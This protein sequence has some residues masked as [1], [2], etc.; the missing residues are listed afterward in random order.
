MRFPRSVSQCLFV[1]ALLGGVRVCA[2]TH[3]TQS[4]IIDPI[5]ETQLT[6]LTGNTPPAAIATN[7]RG[8]V[9]PDLALTDLV[10][11]L[12][13]SS[14]Q[15]AAFDTFV[16]SQYDASSPNFHHWLTPEE[17]GER[18]GPSASDIATISNWLTG[19]GLAISAVSKD[20]L[21]IHFGGTAARV[22][23]AF[24][25]EIHNL[26]VRGEQH[27]GNVS[28][29]QIPTA[30]G[31]VVLGVK[32]LHDFLPR[33]QHRMGSEVILD[34]QTG[35]WQR[36][37][38][39][40]GAARLPGAVP[41]T[42]AS[43]DYGITVGSG[44]N[45][46]TEEDVSPYD[47][48][49][50][51]NVLPL[52]N[53][54]APIDGTNQTIAIAGTSDIILSDVATFRQAFGLPAGIAP[55]MVV[56]NGVDPG[57]CTADFGPC[58][59]D[60][61]VENTLDV[62]L[63]GAV[64]KGASVILV[65]SGQT[66]PTTDKVFSS[67]DYVVENLTSKILSL[68]YGQC[69]LGLGTSGNAAY[70]NLWESAA[71]EG[72]AVFV[73]TGD[74]GSAACDQGLAQSVP[75]TAVY[76][77]SVNGLA[78]SAYDTAVGGTDLNWGSTPA[79]YWNA[80]NNATTGA[81][82]AGY[83]PEVPWN[84]TCT[85]PLA[86]NYLQQWA[87]VLQSHGY[88]ATSPTDPETACNFVVEWWQTIYENTSPTVNI[89]E[90]VNTA[91]AGGGMSNCTANDGETVASCTGGYPK[92]TWQT[93][94]SG[95]PADGKRDLP[96]VSFFSSNG[97]LGSAT[98]IC[99]T[100][101]GAFQCNYS[102]TGQLAVE[103][104]GGTSVATP[105]M[106]GV[107]ALINQQA[108]TTQGNPNAELYQLAS[109]QTYASCKSIG[110]KT[111]NGCFFN[112]INDGTIAMP[113]ES[114][115]VDCTVLHSGDALGILGGY[116]GATGFDLATGLGSLNVDNVV[117]NWV[118]SLGTAAVTVT[119]TPSLGSIPIDQSLSVPVTVSG[120]GGTPTGTVELVGG[121]YTSSVGTLSN[122]AYTF[123]IPA[124]GLS[125]GNDTLTISYSGDATFGAAT[126]TAA[127]TVTKLSPSI[128]VMANPST[129][130]AN[131]GVNVG[132]TVTGSGP[133]PTGTI[134][135]A[136]GGYT[137]GTCTLASGLCTVNIPVNTLAN[138][139]DTL[140]ASYS[141][142][143]DYVAG[144]GSES[145]TV[146]ALTPTVSV[147]ATPS[148]PNTV[149]PMQVTVTVTGT[150]ATPSGTVN[151]GGLIGTLAGGT[152]TFTMAPGSIPG[153]TE[154]LIIEYSGDLTY[155]P[156]SGNVTVTVTKV[157]PTITMTPSATSLNTNDAFTITG[158]VTSA[159]ETPTGQVTVTGG[160]YALI[161]YVSFQGSY[162]IPVQPGALSAGTDTLTATYSGDS[163]FNSATTSTTLS[164]MQ[165]VQIAP[166]ITI[167]FGTN[168]V[169]T[170]ES[171]TATVTVSGTDGTPTGTV[172]ASWNGITPP[173]TQL[174]GGTANFVVPGG[175][176]PVGTYTM[177]VTYGGDPTYL[178][179]STASSFSVTQST[180]GIAATSSGSV[181]PGSLA[182]STITVSSN[183]GFSGI[184][185]LS[186]TLTSS[187]AGASVA[188]QPTCFFTSNMVELNSATT[189]ETTTA[190]VQ[191]TPPATA[192]IA[193]PNLP[194]RR[195]LAAASG[196]VFAF[197]LFLGI[198]SRRSWRRSMLGLIVLLAAICGI[199]SC[200]GNGGGG[201]GG[202]G[203]NTG[204][205]P[206][207]YTFTVTGSTSQN[208]S[209]TPTAT[210][211][212][213]VE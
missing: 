187:P 138:G 95:I 56:G 123:A 137:S 31:P 200:G 117:T 151:L 101:Y 93:N 173:A 165:F 15:Q 20:R 65:V 159:A 211:T 153:G 133:T 87:T 84:D 41:D 119:A 80:T 146:T 75:Y 38:T 3:P 185:N 111:T 92:P 69:E 196:V 79:P 107:M 86:L 105:E 18:F 190:Q 71:T 186:C 82:A 76:G 25:T 206:G 30:L 52:W 169:G 90:F 122:G 213:T 112:D 55:Q 164:V 50:I 42:L 61:L 88:P 73:A 177:S 68:S 197:L 181:E 132:V 184:V 96:D 139:V 48:A 160:N 171:M 210:F 203:G 212:M 74:A 143:G 136:G 97:F 109:K 183:T 155:I 7:D 134:Q 195:N 11:V 158:T 202:G 59:L 108:G 170:D 131:T 83:M 49:T 67:A 26:T 63:S 40:S 54:P 135:L 16:A 120:T 62:E 178:G 98:L 57:V 149:T 28:D 104:V 114:A 179:A 14:A 154:T 103:G 94:V 172:T 116:S 188:N 191:S 27:I 85:N 156:A 53:A 180:Y 1:L 167:V 150:G 66:S 34:Q 23:S 209:P 208:V 36:V 113:C 141:G 194:G 152:Y 44:T 70:S 4:R 199:A 21:T 204:T 17:V 166:T 110:G 89:A 29:P 24:H 35:K 58:T 13:R 10:L 99:V 37:G 205:T 124:Y 127:V 207:T 5:D 2:Q 43:P 142:D 115:A 145:V 193:K 126:E 161:G 100:G 140:T 147:T 72:I 118:S 157:T 64:A 130:G 175:T 125:A 129:I 39:S 102:A 51:Y 121:G 148:N 6:T 77:L 174:W 8:P 78:S 45:A 32:A 19:H 12:R 91:G 176:L 128:T 198:P 168:P 22:E 144:G 60:D 162:S 81:S 192:A 163:F 106:A 47:F 182:N 201:G 9:N 189:S 46:Y 33:P